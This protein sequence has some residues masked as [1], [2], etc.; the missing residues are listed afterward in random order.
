MCTA[1]CPRGGPYQGRGGGGGRV[2]AKQRGPL[3]K[4]AGARKGAVC[5]EML[6][7]QFGGS[8]QMGRANGLRWSWPCMLGAL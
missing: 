3:S 7:N 1:P 8:I 4:R 5:M 6:S 2:H